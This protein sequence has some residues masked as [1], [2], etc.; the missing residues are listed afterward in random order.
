MLTLRD[1]VYKVRTMLGELVENYWYTND[2]IQDLNFAAID[3]CSEAQNLETYFTSTYPANTQEVA[4]PAWMDKIM[5]VAVY[6]GQLFQLECAEDPTDVQVASRCGGTP[7]VFYTKIG[8]PSMSPQG[9]PSN[10]TSSIVEVPLLKPPEV[11]DMSTILGL[12]QI[13]SDDIP[14]HIWCTRHHPFQTKPMDPIY[15]PSRFVQAWIAYAIA[16]GKEKESMLDEAQYW[17]GIFDTGKKA[18]TDFFIMRNQLK[19]PPTYGNGGGALFGRG[20]SSVIFVDQSPGL[21]NM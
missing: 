14:V 5:A 6:S 2:I 7:S 8:A 9:T 19:T 17:Q 3:M 21:Y 12:W 16:R 4:C 20:S 13:P 11:N 1:G 18:M 10:T 15:I